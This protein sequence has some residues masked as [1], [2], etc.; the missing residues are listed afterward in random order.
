MGVDHNGVLH[1]V[2]VEPIKK[3]EEIEGD[4]VKDDY[5]KGTM[6]KEDGRSKL[7]ILRTVTVLLGL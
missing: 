4:E 6:L 3:L 5:Y 1:K 2:L 7:F